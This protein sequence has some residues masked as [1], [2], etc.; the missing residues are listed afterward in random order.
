MKQ[1][2]LVLAGAAAGGLV[3]YLATAWLAGQGIYMLILPGALLGF[4]AGWARNRSVG[5]AVLCGLLALALGVFTA[6]RVAPFVKDGSFGFFLRNIQHVEPVMLIM[7][8]L[9]G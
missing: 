5:V 4:G 2:L 6:W 3:G 9:G 1:P 8:A 7:I